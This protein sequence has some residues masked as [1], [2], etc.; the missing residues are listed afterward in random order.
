M[1]CLVS[2]RWATSNCIQLYAWTGCIELVYGR[3]L[4]SRIRLLGSLK[5]RDIKAEALAAC[6]FSCE[7]LGPF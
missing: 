5:G 6:L 7:F 3:D 1:A 2:S 4:L